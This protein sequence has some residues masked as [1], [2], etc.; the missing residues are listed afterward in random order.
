MGHHLVTSTNTFVAQ[1]ICCIV[2]WTWCN[3]SCESLMPR[4]GRALVSTAIGNSPKYE[5]YGL[6]RDDRY[7]RLLFSHLVTIMIMLRNPIN[8]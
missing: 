2:R 7:L 3:P 1:L 8:I 5:R 6:A 4:L